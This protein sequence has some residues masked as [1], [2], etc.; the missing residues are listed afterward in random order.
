MRSKKPIYKKPFEKVDTVDE[1]VWF[2]NDTPV[3]ESDFTF[4]FN[5]RYPCV[6]G[7]RL[8]IPKE[9]NS[10]F[11]GRSY[12]LAY[13]YGHEQIKKG[14]IAGFNIGMNIGRCAGQTIMWPHIHFIPRHEGDA[15][16]KGGMR[17]AHPGADHYE[18]YSE[19]D[20]YEKNKEEKEDQS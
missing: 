9:N 4:V 20:T 5:D 15:K 11:V 6:E 19:D 7:H 16:Q 3:M 12:G 14:R 2:S 1:S 8:F 10:H 17:H 18:Y 13:D